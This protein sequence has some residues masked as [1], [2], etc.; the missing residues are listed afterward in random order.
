M[1]MVNE[2]NTD[3]EPAPLI[4]PARDEIDSRQKRGGRSKVA[5]VP[6]ASRSGS[7]GGSKTIL[8]ILMSLVIASLV[9]A[10]LLYKRLQ[11]TST[12][13]SDA[14]LR[15]LT[16]E[17]RLS[18]T[19]ESMSESS[20]AMKVKMSEMDTEIRKLWDNVWKRSKETFAEH[21]KLI[22]GQKGQITKLQSSL[23]AVDK[24]I[25][26]N[27]KIVTGL[28]TQLKAAQQ[29]QANLNTAQKQLAAQQS[30][31]QSLQDKLNRMNT[32]FTQLD[33][34][35]SANEEWLESVNGFRRQVNRD[36]NSIKSQLGQPTT[37]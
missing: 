3:L 24:Q 14:E 15:I 33:K 11:E 37:P 30:Q 16:L 13:L 17:K 18:V 5:E 29:M 9:A 26:D 1:S 10:G 20:V 36:L 22:S 25:D 12:M 4:A 32:T 19:D 35:V 28:E 8:V 34:R 6:K 2:N 23:T 27:A 7:H 21:E 31:M